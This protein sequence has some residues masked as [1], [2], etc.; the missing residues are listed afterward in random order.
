[1]SSKNSRVKIHVGRNQKFTAKNSWAKNSHG[2]IWVGLCGSVLW[3][4]FVGL[5]P[6]SKPLQSNEKQTTQATGKDICGVVFL[7]YRDMKNKRQKQDH[8][9]QQKQKIIC[10]YYKV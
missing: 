4:C 8:R 10:L 1:M 2:P 5:F 7:L 3:V 6:V 9:A